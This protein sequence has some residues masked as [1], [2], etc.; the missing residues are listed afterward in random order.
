MITCSATHGYA[1]LLGQDTSIQAQVKMGKRVY[2]RHMG[3]APRGT[4]LA[5]CAYRPR[6]EWAS[7]VDCDGAP[8]PT[9]RKGVEEFLSENGIKL[10]SRFAVFDGL[11]Q[12]TFSASKIPV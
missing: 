3:C 12:I 9:L 8:A 2:E 11:P 4:W 6:Y 10:Q 5:E 7:P 1:P